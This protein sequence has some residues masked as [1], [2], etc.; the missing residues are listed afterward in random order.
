MSKVIFACLLLFILPGVASAQTAET[1]VVDGSAPA[2]PF[3]HFWEQMFG[4][5]RAI[6]S[7]RESYR[8]DL[9]AVKQT[10]GIQYVRFH[11]IFHD[12][13]G[14]YD[15]DKQGQPVFNFSYVDQIYDGLL[16]NGVRPF[17][18]LS[19]MPNKL[20][21][22]PIMQ[23]FWYKPD[24]APPKDWAKWDNLITQFVSHLVDRYGLDEV[25]QWYFEVWNEPNLDFWG[26]DPKQAT[27]WDLYDHT[28]RAVKAVNP[29]LRI[30]GPA[31]AQAA[32]ADAFIQHCA[33]NHVPVDFVSSHVYGNDQ[34][35]DVFGTDENI[36]RDKM[37]CRAV[38]KVHDQIAA[39][40]MPNL[41]LIWSEF[42]ASYFNE[43]AVTDTSY[44]GPWLADTIRQC[45]GLVDVMS[46]W[47]FSDVFE[48]QGVVQTPFYGGFGLLAEDGIPKPAFYAF[49]LLHHLGEQRIAV[50]SDSALL[51]KK[52]D[53]TLVI[54]IW[55]YAPPEKVDAAKT[56]TLRFQGHYRHAIVST[57]DPDHGDVHSIYE[58]MGSPRYL[59]DAQIRQLKQAAE[60]PAAAERN[61]KG[62]E[63]TLTLPSYGLA[64]VE[65][66]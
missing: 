18:E 44:M 48:E 66:R 54:A 49:K 59:S 32:W 39:S 57:V 47:T 36:P 25:S 7:L 42:N 23:A 15:E 26:G 60:L 50:S 34:A 33:A 11:A 55:N 9:Q 12:E 64:V 62:G 5:G 38:K 21:A 22:K 24:V 16:A 51:T 19:F 52:K 17:V 56:I 30:G 29:R 6:L 3:P 40:S 31:T 45:D 10:T 27:Y 61:L 37:V 58:K 28:A 4:S 35:K 8:Q 20:A 1:I 46:Y 65:V 13:V 53:G 14:V 2:H 63:L 41:P 43:P